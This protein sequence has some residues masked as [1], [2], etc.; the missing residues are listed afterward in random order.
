MK[1]RLL[2]LKGAFFPV[3]ALLIVA[4]GAA[5]SSSSTD[6]NVVDP[7]D[8][9]DGSSGSSSGSHSGSSSGSSSGTGDDTVDDSGT[10]GTDAKLT[11]EASADGGCPAQDETVVGVH[12]TFPVTWPSSAASD[13]GSGNV[14][15]W[16]KTTT[17]GGSVT[18][19]TAQTCGLTLPDID[20]NFTGA[21]AVCAPG[22]TCPKKVKIQVNNSTWDKITRTFKVTGSQGGWNPGDKLNTDAALG[23]VGLKDSAWGDNTKAWPAVCTA[24]C[25]GPANNG[26]FVAADTSDDDMDSHPGFTANPLSNSMYTYPPTT[27]TAF[28]VPPLADEVYLASRNEIAVSTTRKTDC[29]HASGTAKI[30]RFDNHVVGCHIKSPAGACDS[31]AVSFLDQNRTLYGPDANTRASTSS[32]IMGTAVIQQLPASATCA[33]VRAVK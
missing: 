9:D 28:S 1:R 7:G 8:D 16:L 11:I 6:G 15:I 32:P 22:M 20:L 23:L 31:G 30:T 12:I 3:T 26:A 18:M 25:A 19:G 5:C 10:A 33:D 29:T 24:N 13:M 27:I 14:E 17:K 21:A 4:A 2:S